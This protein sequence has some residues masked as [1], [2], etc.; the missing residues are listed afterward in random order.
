MSENKGPVEVEAPVTQTGAT[1]AERQAA[2]LRAEK[3]SSKQVDE[4]ADKVEDKAVKP[5]AT[6]KRTAKKS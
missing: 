6:K 4:S 1:F 3:S 5:A 2:R